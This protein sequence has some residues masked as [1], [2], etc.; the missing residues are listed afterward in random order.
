MLLFVQLVGMLVFS[1]LQYDRFNL[2]KRFCGLLTGLDGY[3]PRP[4]RPRRHGFGASVLA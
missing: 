1:T 4:P 2:T 3:R